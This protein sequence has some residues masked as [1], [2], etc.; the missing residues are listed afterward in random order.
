MKKR[1]IALLTAL[2]LLLGVAIGAGAAGSGAA[3]AQAEPTA[4]E[5][6][7]SGTDAEGT[8]SFQNL[9]TRVRTGNYTLLACSEQLASLDAM[10]RET[11]YD[12]L[13]EANNLLSEAIMLLYHYGQTFQAEEYR[14]QQEE[15]LDQIEALKPE[16]YEKTYRES[17]RQID[18]VID[19]IVLGAQTVYITTLSLERSLA[20]GERGLAALDRS[21]SEMELRYGLGQ[22]SELTL[23]N[24]KNTRS[25][26]ASGLDS[27]RVQIE[28]LK[29]QLQA[30]IG[31]TPTGTLTLLALPAVTD[32][33]IG[34]MDYDTDLAAAKEAS[35]ALYQ[36]NEAAEDAQEDWKDA[37][38]GY[39]KEMARHTYQAA[40]YTYQAAVQSLELDFG[41]LYRAVGDKRQVLSAAQDAL[42]YEEK[43]CAAA[44]KKYELGMIS[45]SAL[46]DAQDALAAAQDTV[47]SA[48]SD[49]LSA[50]NAYQWAVRGTIAG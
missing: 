39:Q 49:L 2:T 4:A 22:V 17:V 40:V 31:E 30:M 15:L 32:D 3:A 36:K 18:A 41:T 35:L 38:A 37:D 19:Q 27:L 48:E 45:A 33:E 1:W 50:Y 9:E 42:A 28:S 29:A 11:A 13:T 47:T 20:A 34:A 14:K 16:E 8:L 23:L 43:A 5:T 24:L 26:T 44:E 12:D 7:A 21:V 6:D 46:A 10:D 25:Q